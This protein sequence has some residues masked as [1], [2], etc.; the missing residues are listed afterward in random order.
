[1]LQHRPCGGPVQS[2][3]RRAH[4]FAHFQSTVAVLGELARGARGRIGAFAQ[5]ADRPPHLAIATLL[6]AGDHIVASASLC[7]GTVSPAGADAAAIRHLDDLRQAARSRRASGCDPAEHEARHRRDDQ[8][9]PR[10][11][12]TFPAVAAI[13]HASAIAAL[14]DNTFATPLSKPCRPFDL[15][16][17]SSPIPSPNGSAATASPSAAWSMDGGRFDWGASGKFPT[18]TEPYTGYDGLI[19]AEEF[20][21]R[22]PS[23]CGRAPEG[24]HFGACLSPTHAFHLLQGVETLPLRMDR[25]V[26]NT[27]AVLAF[28]AEERCGR[29]GQPS[30]ARSPSRSRSGAETSAEGR[31]PSSHSDQGRSR[32]AQVHRALQLASHL[33]NVGDAKT[34]VIIQ[35]RRRIAR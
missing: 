15:G 1:M 6:N 21:T 18:L 4:L 12:S 2:G 19:F 3:S 20:R 14:I 32:R 34:L 10:K 29:L 17:T 35:P 25:H 27:A 9:G 7:G 16:P 11:C 24:L 5:P 8:S 23:R 28:L 26:A 30:D 33:A 22:S 13:A 31:A